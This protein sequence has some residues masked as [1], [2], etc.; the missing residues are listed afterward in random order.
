VRHKELLSYKQ[1][2]VSNREKAEVLEGAGPY[3]ILSK[4]KTSN[5][6][7]LGILNAGVRFLKQ[8]ASAS[9]MAGDKHLLRRQSNPR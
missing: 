6:D 7:L 9:I 3:K 8:R 5:P 2:E 4:Q 1:S